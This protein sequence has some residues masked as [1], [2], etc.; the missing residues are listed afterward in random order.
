MNY[1]SLDI[2]KKI[3]LPI[4]VISLIGTVL[5]LLSTLELIEEQSR[6]TTGRTIE[7]S[8]YIIEEEF[9]EA[10]HHL[11]PETTILANSS[12]IEDGIVG[13]D[14]EL[15]LEELRLSRD[16]FVVDCIRA[17]DNNGN[18]LAHI[19]PK[20]PA[21]KTLID[22]GKDSERFS[23]FARNKDT[24]WINAIAPVKLH[25][26]D[27]IGY[28]IAGNQIDQAFLKRVKDKTGSEIILEYSNLFAGSSTQAIDTAIR[29]SFEEDH[30]RPFS[31]GMI[32]ERSNYILDR[33]EIKTDG[34]NTANVYALISTSDNV[35]AKKRNTLSLLAVNLGMLLILLI[36]SYLVASNI[37]KPLRMMSKRARMIADGNYMQRIE[38]TS[39]QEIDELATSF[40]IM[41]DSLERN[42][43]LL[44][45]K[46][47]TDGLTGLFNHRYFHDSLANEIN[48][49][50]RYHHPLSIIMA[51]IDDFKK[52]NDTFGHKK[53][54]AALQMLAERMRASIRSA[55]IACRIGGEEFAI[56]L[57][58][59]ASCDAYSVAER[60]RLDISSSTLEDIGRITISLGVAT[61]P[62]HA[63]DKDSLIVAADTA[64]YKAKRKGKNLTLI[65][66]GEELYGPVAEEDKWLIEEAYYIDTLH[67]LAA[68]V[69]AKDRYTHSHSE[70]VASF[71]TLIGHEL[72]LSHNRVE[73]LRIA[74]LLHDVG[75]I[76]IPDYILRKEGALT[77][78]EFQEIRLH[79]IFSERILTRTKL[80]P[81]LKAILYHHERLDGSGYPYGLEAD[82]IPLEARILA[83]ADT[84]EAMCSDR[85]Y[86]QALSIEE[87]IRELKK[88][89][90][91]KLDEVAVDALVRIIERD[92]SVRNIVARRSSNLMQA[93][94]QAFQEEAL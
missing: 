20:M 80:E 29:H 47:Y 91:E 22:I 23:L 65:Y 48:R 70:H 92:E 51:D 82:A 88:E 37:S 75:K 62:D 76:G 36:A 52:I 59:T 46:A 55:D 16:I 13:R 35:D 5:T 78:E 32:V 83:V 31:G 86:R 79:P 58:E 94:E 38:Y 93:L 74:G 18:E 6:A 30:F 71:A 26:G 49:V 33:I 43:L 9:H 19:G 81:V 27:V 14:K 54:D 60:L 44:E 90:G 4:I 67:A 8:R 1:Q 53:G 10:E 56:I 72:A 24:V 84:F 11:V 69:D 34:G 68:A 3:L 12:V 45:K 42:R 2:G 41:S 77:D 39:I 85:P 89:R 57:P 40:N 63:L 87:A 66:D 21:H 28:I 15:L 17:V 61:F 25:N 50:Y 7:Q 73:H 64:M